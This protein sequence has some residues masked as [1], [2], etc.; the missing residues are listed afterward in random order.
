MYE[1]FDHTADLGMRV[2][3]GT[4]VELLAEAGRALFSVIVAN[5]ASVRPLQERK[6]RIEGSDA[7]QDY[8]LF[9]WLNELLYTYET[10]L[11]LLCD[12]NVTVGNSGLEAV[13]RGETADPARHQ[14]DHEVKAITYHDLRVCRDNGG[15]LAEFIVDI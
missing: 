13:C 9:D 6:F 15:W 4:L 7:E 2:R 10:E 14:L 1:V 11:L 3:A 12:F 5:P 8:L